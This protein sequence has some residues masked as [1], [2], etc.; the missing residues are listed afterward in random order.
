MKHYVR[1]VALGV[2]ALGVALGA[3]GVV[4]AA[5]PIEFRI[6]LETGPDHSRNK[7]FEQF[8]EL[9]NEKSGGSL[10]ATIYAGG[11]LFK[12]RDVPKA[13]VQGTIDMSAPGT[14]QL[15][16]FVPDAD[17]TALPAFYGLEREQLYK[18]TDGPIGKDLNTLIE[19]K[20]RSKVLGRWLDL[21]FQ[22]TYGISKAPVKSYADFK[23]LKVRYPGGTVNSE[24]YKY[25]G[26]N[27][28]LIPWPDVPL[29]LIQGTVDGVQTTTE[30]IRSAKLWDSGLKYAFEDKQFIAQYVPLVSM[31]FWNKLT[32]EQQ[33]MISSSWEER[34][35]SMRDFAHERQAE[36]RDVCIKN[37]IEF[38]SPTVEQRAK[39][40]QELLTTQDAI[41]KELD[42][43]ADIAKRATEAV[44]KA[45]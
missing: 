40:R 5:D 43:N 11:S 41:I 25:F 44:D 10:K 45:S 17:L 9:I 26:S 31:V 32:P 37:G 30:S 38:T 42:M 34:I 21:G 15:S 6:S 7:S 18:I 19:N 13:L 27:T 22:N 29:A 14:W 20:L 3:P 33:N 1:G 23:G 36:A 16:A 2:A 24:R 8:V 28:V 12:G 4:S 39:A 35:D